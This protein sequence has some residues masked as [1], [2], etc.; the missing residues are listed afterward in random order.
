[1]QKVAIVLMNLGGPSDL[2]AVRP[3]LF[4]LFFDPNIIPLPKPFR[5]LLAHF[6]SRSRDK[7]AQ[8][9]YKRLGGKS[10][11]LE[12][13]IAQSRALQE[14]LNQHNY[15]QFKTFVCMRYWH[16]MAIDVA[17]NVNDF[18]PDQIIML[19]LYPQFSTT[20]TKSSFEDFEHS[21]QIYLQTKTHVKIK[22]VGCYPA[23]QQLIEAFCD[24]AIP[25]LK[26]SLE[27][28]RPH[29]LLSAHG[30]PQSV[31]DKGDPYQLQV[32]LTASLIVARLQQTFGDVFDHTVCYQSKVGPK[33]WLTPATDTEIE[34]KSKQKKPVVVLPV[35]FVSD[36]SETLVE[37]DQD[38]RDLALYQGCPYYIRVPSLAIHAKFIA[39]LKN[40]VYDCLEDKVSKT[41]CDD[42][43]ICI[44]KQSQ[45]KTVQHLDVK[46]DDNDSVNQGN[47]NV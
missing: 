33:K 41:Y 16:P 31:I 36:H 27:F 10:P 3:F 38:Y 42:N 39:L 6:I 21:F 13:T 12:N 35:A 2:K 29:L 24:L 30:L 17:R 20:T 4:N 32:E 23:D 40:R 18:S 11:L 37:L 14:L 28:G 47:E 43:M 25:C 1:M 44:C 34:D 22:K 19:P 8:N 5:Y 46:G 7:K 26:K 45:N 9:I 15:F